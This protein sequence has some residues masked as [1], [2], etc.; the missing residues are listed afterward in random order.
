MLNA[1]VSTFNIAGSLSPVYSA[2][3]NETDP[4][5]ILT[6]TLGTQV[7]KRLLIGP[8]SGPDATPTFRELLKSDV[9]FAVNTTDVQSSIGGAKTFTSDLAI[10]GTNTN[11]FLTDGL[12]NAP[13]LTFT[14]NSGSGFSYLNSSKTLFVSIDGS[15]Y[16]QFL[17]GELDIKNTSTAFVAESG[18]LNIN[19][20]H[21]ADTPDPMHP[22]DGGVSVSTY[23]GT[24]THT[25]TFGGRTA[26]GTESLPA[27]TAINQA[28]VEFIGK[29]Y[30]LC[31]VRNPES[32]ECDD[33]GFEHTN[34]GVFGVYAAETHTLESQGTYCDIQTTRIG[35]TNNH[36]SFLVDHAGN[37][38]LTYNK[39]IPLTYPNGWS[40]SS[41]ATDYDSRFLT[42]ESYTSTNSDAGL[43]IQNSNGSRGL[44]IWM[45]NSEKISYLDNIINNNSGIV[46]TRMKTSTTPVVAITTGVFDKGGGA[47][48]GGTNFG[49]D[50]TP[51]NVLTVGS[52]SQ[53]QMDGNGKI[54]KYSSTITD[55]E[56]LIGKTSGS[57]F[58]KTTL[59]GSSGISVTNGG[60]AIT[61]SGFG[62]SEQF[63][64][65]QF[66]PN[67]GTNY[68]GGG[69]VQSSGTTA[70]VC[71]IYIPKTGT[72]KSCYVVF[73]NAGILASNETS[74]IAI[75]VNNTSDNLISSS[76]TNDTR[77]TTFSNT[78][79]SVSVNAGDYIEI[80]WVTPTWTTN[81]TSVRISG[82]IYI[83]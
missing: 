51:D 17:D 38:G 2:T 78:A 12:E 58:E 26:N 30:V 10:S 33:Y 73:D 49:T 7:T 67:N 71:R 21:D 56:L 54:V 74:T 37:C 59:T 31:P 55:G 68:Y 61:L 60:G 45:D 36:F 83:E 75:R 72:I 40:G 25:C 80:K 42:I 35:S 39:T 57:T 14:S 5:P 70:G 47:F 6:F 79:M 11:L 82:N 62:Y 46:Q 9:P 77:P 27:S 8:I 3:L 4:D 1:Q 41:P 66:N 15:Y 52:S 81:P 18:K 34:R 32:G 65:G 63:S 69:Q 43:F 23:A 20:L 24:M 76:V 13:A 50:A 64:F 29:G 48:V 16:Y 28:M 53:L 44:N 22:Q 19:I